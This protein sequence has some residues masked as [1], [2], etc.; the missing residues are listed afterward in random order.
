MR[1]CEQSG[2]ERL[3]LVCALAAI[4]CATV[5]Q[6]CHADEFADWA[7]SNE[8][9]L[10]DLP[11]VRECSHVVVDIKCFGG[12]HKFALDT[13]AT[14]TVIDS[15]L[16]EKLGT[17]LGSAAMHNSLAELEGDFVAMP[18][19]LF[20]EY[21]IQSKYAVCLDARHLSEGIGYQIT[22]V[23]GLDALERCVV[24]LDSAGGRF[25]LFRSVPTDVVR[26]SEALRISRDE[27]GWWIH[28]HLPD[29]S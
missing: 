27:H 5:A 25:R 16:R 11:I 7:G 19:L 12:V 15:S 20:G 18:K 29:G 10:A 24:E 3:W 1:L 13:G 26:E 22:G 8:N 6:P 21:R 14:R 23:I 2:R 17:S 9:L 28:A 4:A